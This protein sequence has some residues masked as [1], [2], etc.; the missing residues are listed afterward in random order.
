MS[1]ETR[2]S[3]NSEVKGRI[4]QSEHVGDSVP[5]ETVSAGF[6]D[7]LYVNPSRATHVEPLECTVRG[8]PAGSQLPHDVAQGWKAARQLCGC[9][10]VNGDGLTPR[11][12]R[13]VSDLVDRGGVNADHAP[14]RQA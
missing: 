2:I 14:A 11:T 8:Q 5:L 12:R 1:H 7:P 6:G 10:S 4:G 13:G 3:D 9:E